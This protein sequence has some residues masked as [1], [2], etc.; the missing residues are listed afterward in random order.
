MT[1]LHDLSAD[2]LSS[3]YRAGQLSGRGDARRARPTEFRQSLK[4]G[5]QEADERMERSLYYRAVG[6]SYDAVKIFC[7]KNGKVTRVPYREHMPPTSRRT[8]H[9]RD[10]M[11]NEPRR[12][13]ALLSVEQVNAD[14]DQ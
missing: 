4:V 6:Y 7:D 2:T 1:A 13:R 9:W 14:A 11:T 5:K 8:A 12:V 3:A 10:V